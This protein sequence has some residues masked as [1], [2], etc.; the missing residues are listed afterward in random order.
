MSERVGSWVALGLAAFLGGAV[1]AP[2]QDPAG[3]AGAV[4]AT[5]AGKPITVKDVDD[6]VGAQ[7]MELRAREHQLRSQ[8]LDALVAQ[9][10]T[11]QAV[12]RGL[13][14]TLA[15]GLMLE[16]HLFTEVF[17][18]DDSRIGVASFLE[19]GPGKAEFTGR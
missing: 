11:K 10:L 15:E 7:L 13:G 4:A 18:T 16:R 2:G 19:H 6:V 9:A 17:T 3:A 1:P 12:D 14:Q 5:V 8:A